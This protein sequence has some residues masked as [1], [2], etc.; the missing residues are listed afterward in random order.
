MSFYST[1]RVTVHGAG[2]IGGRGGFRVWGILSLFSSMP[3]VDEG[4]RVCRSQSHTSSR[5]DTAQC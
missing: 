5:R 3:T 4:V 2:A 1:W